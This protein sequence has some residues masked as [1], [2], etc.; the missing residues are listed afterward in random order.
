MNDVLARSFTDVHAG[1][2][3]Q[4]ARVLTATGP[5]PGVEAPAARR[6]HHDDL[7][8]WACAVGGAFAGTAV[9]IGTRVL[10]D[11][12]DDVL[13][14]VP[15]SGHVVDLGCG[16]GLLA[17]AAARA[18]PTARTTATD[19]SADAVASARLTAAANGLADRVDVR[20]ADAGDTLPAAC[21]DLV[22]LNPPFHVGGTVHTAIASK[23][24]RAAARLLA[25][26]GTLVTVWNSHLAYRRELERVV[27]PTRQ[28]T[29]TPKFTLTLSTRRDGARRDPR[30]A[31]GEGKITP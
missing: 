3:R 18:L 6:V 22:L 27:G 1:L 21:A 24:F 14:A 8:L 17:A 31:D 10:L 9:D 12:L 4:K 19:S 16:T 26:G 2:G 23:L 15:P 28:V 29:R 7:G 25:P 20:R 30:T 5:R 13:A 11:H